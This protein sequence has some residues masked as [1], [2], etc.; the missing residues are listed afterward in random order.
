M[1]P[2]QSSAA[3]RVFA[4][5]ELLESILLEVLR[6]EVFDRT[7]SHDKK[8]SN[9]N[10]RVK[11]AKTILHT[12]R[13]NKKFQSCIQGSPALRRHLGLGLDT[14]RLS[15]Q[16]E[17]TVN[18]LILKPHRWIAPWRSQIPIHGLEHFSLYNND[19]GV[20]I[21]FEIADIVRLQDTLRENSASLLKMWVSCP[22]PEYLCLSIESC[23]R[24]AG[25]GAADGYWWQMEMKVKAG[26]LGVLIGLA[27]SLK[28]AAE[29]L[30]RVKACQEDFRIK[31]GRWEDDWRKW[32][33]VEQLEMI[34]EGPVVVSC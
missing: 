29:G 8:I 4:T 15:A 12:Q 11:C 6:T 3:T 25:T 17:I 7:D 31:K 27:V 14:T 26:V 9:H 30:E 23:H 10:E 34:V 16:R 13:I 1:T 22:M 5:T 20:T 28:E 32:F 24:D 18:A 19:N 21:S 2:P 33:T